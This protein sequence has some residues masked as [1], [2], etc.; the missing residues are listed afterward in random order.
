MLVRLILP[1]IIA[2]KDEEDDLP[3]AL[4]SLA[5]GNTPVT[6]IV[7]DN[8]SSDRTADFANEF[9][10]Y[11][12]SEPQRGKQRAISTGLAWLFSQRGIDETILFADA[13]VIARPTWAAS[14]NAAV[15][16]MDKERPRVVASTVRYYEDGQRVAKN[17]LLSIMATARD[18]R[19][20]QN[21]TFRARGSNMAIHPADNVRLAESFIELGDIHKDAVFQDKAMA[22]LVL[23]NDGQAAQ[24]FNPNSQM[25]ARGDRYPTIRS[26][27][28]TLVQGVH[29]RTN[30][31]YADWL[32][33]EALT[34]SPTN[35]VQ[36]YAAIAVEAELTSLTS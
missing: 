21:G 34:C 22:E 16:Q 7:I 18:L 23:K 25:L 1:L 17:G 11:V 31:L 13:D 12:L 10:A 30:T 24:L 19:A 2:A 14:L 35:S 36:H 33:T 4:L 32:P 26:A 15:Q 9:G 20:H 3:A 28:M 8:R 5:L 6:P 29:Y 27:L